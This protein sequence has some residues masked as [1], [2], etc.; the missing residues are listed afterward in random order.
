MRV[1]ARK[2]CGDMKTR[3]DKLLFERGFA[4]SRERAQALIL[5]GKVLVNGQKIEKSGTD[6]DVESDIRLLGEDLKYVSRGGLK[7][8]KALAHWKI[9]V[10]GKICL[11]VGASTGGFTDCLLQYHARQ[12]HAFDVGKG[13]IAWKL[14]SDPRVIVR[15]EFNVRH[16]LSE[17]LP[18]GVSLVTVDLSFIS[19]TKVLRPLKR[20]LIERVETPADIVLLV[21]PQF[22]AGKGEVGKGG[23]VRDPEVRSKAVDSVVE[24]A[25]NEG[26]QVVGSIPSPVPGAKGNQEFLLYLRL[27]PDLSSGP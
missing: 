19:L 20:A 10:G 9:D 24:C 5:A 16:M 8:E 22:E 3:L 27:T 4:N 13:Q 15:D 26:Y 14:R 7:L 1:L 25:N 12:V 11:D 2:F 21:K 17:D 6:I 23:V 18:A